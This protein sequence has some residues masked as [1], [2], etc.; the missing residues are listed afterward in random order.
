MLYNEAK[1]YVKDVSWKKIAVHDA[2]SIKGFFGAYRFLSNFHLCEVEV[3]GLVYPSSENAFQALKVEEYQRDRFVNISPLDS[4]REWKSCD[5]IDR[6][7][8]E[9][10]ARKYKVMDHVV[11]CKFDQNPD[12][13][14]LLLDTGEK[15][16]E[17]S[18]WWRDLFWGY[19]VNLKKGENN[20]GKILMNIRQEFRDG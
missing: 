11:W 15:Y 3:E 9:W 13:K 8:R 18:L 12:L 4:K 17:E 19:D 7:A 14:K 5:L 16:L 10:D 20:L 2:K 1:D 6:N